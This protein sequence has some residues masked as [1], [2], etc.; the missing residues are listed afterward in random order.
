MAERGFSP[1]VARQLVAWPFIG[2]IVGGF[3]WGWAV[4]IAAVIWLMQRETLVR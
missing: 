1:A 4:G 2:N 3:V